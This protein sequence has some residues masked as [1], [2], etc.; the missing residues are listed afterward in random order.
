MQVYHLL[1]KATVEETVQAYF[2][3]RLGRAAAALA[4]VTGEDPE[5]IKGTLNGQLESEIDPRHVYQ[6]ALVEGD[7]NKQ[8]QKE[9]A[10]AV[11]RAKRAYEIAT[12]SLFRDVS[13]YS[14]DS[15]RRELAPDL[16][17]DDLRHVHRALPARHRRQ[18]QRKDSFLEFLTPD[19]LRTPELPERVRNATFDRELAIQ[20]PDAEFLALGHPF[21]DA[22]L[23]HAG[24]YDFGGLTAVRTIA[25]PKLAGRSGFLFAFVVRQRITREDG[26]ECLFRFEPVFV[27]AEGR[28]DDDAAWPAA[29][30][31][32][33]AA[34]PPT[35]G[36]PDAG[37]AFDAAR[38]RLEETAGVW[39]WADD[40][41]FLGLS[42][43]VFR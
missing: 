31:D 15:Y 41:E 20:R 22:M 1:N 7:L 17:L 8:T 30:A 6:R 42:W 24:S 11:E 40:V 12:R 2:E 38:R 37:A 10:E 16:T 29:T 21:I 19:V 43:V 18:L 28:I 34:A 32:A 3:D 9:I 39:D 35:G 14:F 25:E 13:S 27:T 33:D 23:R 26:D 5:E 4:K 36:I